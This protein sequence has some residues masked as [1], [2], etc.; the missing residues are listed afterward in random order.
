MTPS[1]P[2]GR[3]IGAGRAAD[4]YELDVARVLRR[5][6]IPFDVAPEAALMSYPSERGFPVAEVF[7][8][9]GTDLVRLGKII[10]AASGGAVSGHI[11]DRRIA[12]DAHSPAPY[13]SG[14]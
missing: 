5:Y 10:R 12:A 6:R 14:V 7:G 1:A 4:V 9:D 2:P 3:L 13:Y 11:L 8:T